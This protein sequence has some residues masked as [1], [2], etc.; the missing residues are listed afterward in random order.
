MLENQV[1][2]P[3]K[4]D[5]NGLLGPATIV[6][7]LDQEIKNIF[8]EDLLAQLHSGIESWCLDTDVTTEVIAPFKN[9]L[10]NGL[11]QPLAPFTIRTSFHAS[12]FDTDPEELEARA[13]LALALVEEKTI[14]REFWLGEFSSEAD[15]AGSWAENPFLLDDNIEIVS[16]VHSPSVGMA[17][18]E[19]AYA[20]RSHGLLPTLYMPRSAASRLHL[21]EHTDLHETFRNQINTRVIPGSGFKADPGKSGLTLSDNQVP[22]VI[23][24]PAVVLLGPV[25]ITPDE[26][27]QAISRQKNDIHYFAERQAVVV[28][29]G[30]AKFATVID[31]TQ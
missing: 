30:G 22:A 7:E 19:G 13:T 9:R 6:V 8:V 23:S 12:T 1:F 2:P 18:L 28:A 25:T 31:V 17:V 16:G 15:V 20:D 26:A 21:R 29:L 24:G 3:L 4:P 14:E 5:H 10:E 11:F 27:S